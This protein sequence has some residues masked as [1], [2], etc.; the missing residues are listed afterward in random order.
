MLKYYHYCRLSG[1]GRRAYHAVA[2]AICHYQSTAT[3]P[4]VS[5]LQVVVDAVKND[6]PHFFYV[7]WSAVIYQTEF[8]SRKMLVHLRYVMP[9]E[10]AKKYLAEARRIAAGLAG[11][12][13]ATRL[14][15][16]HDYIAAHTAYNER[17]GVGG[18]YR[19]NDHTAIGP[20][21]EGLA[22]C[23]G[24]SRAAQLLSRELGIDC[25]YQCGYI[26]DAKLGVRGHHAWNIVMLDGKSLKMDVTW[27]LPT[28]GGRVSHKYFCVPC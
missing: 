24:I 2:T 27:D 28:R 13:A 9:K 4:A 18:S 1:E 11:G 25:T 3:F 8:F 19:R 17:C 21:F 10:R 23:E 15:R 12:S 5:N 20:L 6:N 16:V 14:R 26:S 22:V 7:D